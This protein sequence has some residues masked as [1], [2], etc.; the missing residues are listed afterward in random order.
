M[1]DDVEHF[2]AELKVKAFGDFLNRYVLEDGKIEAGDAR[3]DDAV[4]ARIPSQ[5][6]TNKWRQRRAC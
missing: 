1:I 5:V 2:N 6:K 3:T 4:P